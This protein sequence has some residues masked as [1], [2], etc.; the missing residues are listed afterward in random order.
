MISEVQGLGSYR[1]YTDEYGREF[2]ALLDYGNTIKVE[3][4]RATLK[5]N[6][7]AEEAISPQAKINSTVDK[8]IAAAK[9]NNPN[10]NTS[11][12]NNPKP[13]NNAGA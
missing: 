8:I 11:Q 3:N 4:S 1:Q 9:R 13:S 5:T 2:P 12:A 10:T 6:N 7:S